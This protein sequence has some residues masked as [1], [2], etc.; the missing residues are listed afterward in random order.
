MYRPGL[1][2]VT[3]IRSPGEGASI[4]RG[5]V[6]TSRVDPPPS[7]TVYVYGAMTRS[8]RPTVQSAGNSPS[9][10]GILIV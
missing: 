8:T 7:V 9:P 6:I 4:A 3:S 10:P 1:N 5:P 2:P